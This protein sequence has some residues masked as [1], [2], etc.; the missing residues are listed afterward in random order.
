MTKI[1]TVLGTRP[2]I[3]K[4]SRVISEFDQYTDHVL[5][6]TGQNY[7]Y[8]LNQIF[9]DQL[10]I[11]QPDHYLNVSGDSLFSTIGSIITKVGH[12]L[13]EERP[14][15][16]LFYGDT[17]SC[18]GVIAAKRLKIPIFHMEAGNRSFDQR[19]PEELNRKVV[20]HLSD[21]NFVLT[22][23]GR[24]YLIQEGIS[25]QTII[26]SGSHMAEVLDFYMP[27]IKKSDVLDR[28]NL[29]R[30]DYFVV[31]VHREENVD[32]PENLRLL[33]ETF[34]SVAAKYDV[35]VLVSVHPRTLKRIGELN[36]KCNNEKVI[37]HKPFGFFDYVFLQMNARCV[38]SDSGT[39]SEEC[40]ILK[41]NAVTIR[42][43]H[44][45]PESNDAGTFIMCGLHKDNVLQAVDIVTESDNNSQYN[46]DIGDILDYKG[47]IASKIILRS[48]LGYIPYVN[49]T[50]WFK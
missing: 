49:R 34:D 35:P 37:F 11:R 7:D 48:V 25:P 29:V 1:V 47:K 6:H 39:V 16:V 23:H 14:D 44:E 5:V 27:E 40:S 24:R 19:I 33:L 10:K 32:T 3:I 38:I 46:K 31:S 8:E 36:V 43:S 42:N 41:L 20:D 28:L 30:G 2:E 45:R 22:E 12:I 9:F 13:E 21:I 4:M 15:G 18:L 50:V 17:N 26:K